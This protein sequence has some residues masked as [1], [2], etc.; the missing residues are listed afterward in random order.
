[1]QGSE[2]KNHINITNPK[3]LNPEELINHIRKSPL[4]YLNSVLEN[5]Q[6]SECK[7]AILCYAV[8]YG[9]SYQQYIDFIKFSFEVLKIDTK[10][11]NDLQSINKIFN[12]EDLAKFEVE[13][14]NFAKNYPINKS[15]DDLNSEKLINCL[16]TL[17]ILKD[18]RTPMLNFRKFN[19]ICLYSKHI[20]NQNITE[21]INFVCSLIEKEKNVINTNSIDHLIEEENVTNKNFVDSLYEQANQFLNS[22]SLQNDYSLSTYLVPPARI[23]PFTTNYKPHEYILDVSEYLMASAVEAM[24]PVMLSIFI[25]KFL[26][27]TNIFNID[28][29]FECSHFRLKSN[30]VTYLFMAA[31]YNIT[32]ACNITL[33]KFQAL[34]GSFVY[35]IEKILGELYQISREN[36]FE[37]AKQL[38]S[39]EDCERIKKELIDFAENFPVENP[40]QYDI[41]CWEIA[42]FYYKLKSSKLDINLQ[43]DLIKNYFE[44]IIRNKLMD[45][46]NLVYQ[47]IKKTQNEITIDIVN[48]LFELA[49]TFMFFGKYLL[50]SDFTSLKDIKKNE[51]KNKFFNL[52]IAIDYGFSLEKFYKSIEFFLNTIKGILPESIE[53]N[54]TIYTLFNDNKIDKET[55][56]DIKKQLINFLRNYGETKLENEKNCEEIVKLDTHLY[57]F[58]KENTSIKNP[59]ND[60]LFKNYNKIR[61]YLIK[62]INCNDTNEIEFVVWCI[63]KFP[64]NIDSI[65]NILLDE[66]K[67]YENKQQ[68]QVQ[69]T[70]LPATEP[71]PPQENP[72]EYQKEAK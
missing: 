38:L 5:F 16:S 29:M 17:R 47:L 20:I 49:S 26:F 1:M 35:K 44:V 63:N 70:L 39:P 41:F 33:L 55:K 58:A 72:H 2:P 25:D 43:T 71:V 53:Q 34:I 62:I 10:I 60:T 32:F 59:L 8:E 68:P 11:Q 18:K 4:G 50:D 57:S 3:D 40:S 30:M 66:I 51:N 46:I 64:G 31:A 24:K 36:Q 13:L 23:Y 56:K 7:F 65:F 61:R 28:Y 22:N 69:Q 37:N 67:E 42:S 15:Q 27:E 54:K 19:C 48:S 14:T 45:E 52:H 9:C 6:K 21:E 12:A